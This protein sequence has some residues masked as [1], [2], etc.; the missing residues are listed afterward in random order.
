MAG[1]ARRLQHKGSNSRKTGANLLGCRTFLAHGC[2]EVQHPQLY[3]RETLICAE[4]G[5]QAF[6]LS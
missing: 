5:R 6:N 3:S 1:L 4:Y 2:T